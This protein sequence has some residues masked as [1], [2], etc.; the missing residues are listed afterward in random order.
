MTALM[1][2]IKSADERQFSADEVPQY[3]ISSF[4]KATAKP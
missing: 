2:S 4:L 1:Y 3:I